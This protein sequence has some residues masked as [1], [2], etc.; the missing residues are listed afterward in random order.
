MTLCSLV[1]T[2]VLEEPAVRVEE[3]SVHLLP[4]LLEQKYQH[5]GGI[6]CLIISSTLKIEEAGSSDT[7]VLIFQ[8]T[9]LFCFL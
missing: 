2:N 1:V 9:R 7:L 8:V 3:V 4:P 5:F 6:C